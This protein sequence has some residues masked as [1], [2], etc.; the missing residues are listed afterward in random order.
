MDTLRAPRKRDQKLW[1]WRHSS[2][3]RPVVF[4]DPG[5]V[6]DDVVHLHLEQRVVRRLLGRFT[7]QGFV[8]HDLSRACF[9][10]ATDSI[11]RVILLGRLALYGEGAARLHEELIPVTARWTDPDIRKDV[12]SPY[13]KDTEAKT[14]A[15]LEDS[16]LEG[17]GI[18]LTDEVVATLQNAAARDIAELLPH[19]EIRGTEYAADAEKKLAARGTA[20]AKAMR[21]ILE[22]QQKHISTTVKRINKLNPNQLR[23]DFGEVEDELLQLDANKRYW[24]KRLEEIRNELKTEPAR[25]EDLYTVKATRVEPVGL[26]YLWPVT[27]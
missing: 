14:L 18:K 2:P 1:E 8:H 6:G 27:G 24:A 25:I 26:V 21:E 9:A 16:L 20:E 23:L 17:S 7:A 4:E 22:T 11:P 19:L 5:L 12:L 3:I 15:L 10:Q 13:A